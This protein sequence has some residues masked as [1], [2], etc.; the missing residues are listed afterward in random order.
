MYGWSAA[1][2][3]RPPCADA[4]GAGRPR[5]RRELLKVAGAILFGCSLLPHRGAQA[6]AE[7]P[8]FAAGSLAEVLRSLGGQPTAGPQISLAVP[9][10]VENGAVVPVEVTSHLPGAQSIYIISESNPFPLVARLDFPEDTVPYV[11]TRIKVARSCD[12]YAVVRTGDRL[13][14]TSKGT[15]VTV[16]GCGG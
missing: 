4:H 12:I 9:D 1:D 15:Q 5:T 3:D 2:P 13:Y 16:G 14:W 10:L 8:A 6:A 7:E 11:A